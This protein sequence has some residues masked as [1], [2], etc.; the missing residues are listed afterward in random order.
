MHALW[1]LGGGSACAAHTL[2]LQKI[3]IKNYHLTENA[4]KKRSI[5]LLESPDAHASMPTTPR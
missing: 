2:D 5:A 1:A 4:L 3:E